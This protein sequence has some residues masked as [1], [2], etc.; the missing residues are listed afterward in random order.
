MQGFK[1]SIPGG[2]KKALSDRMQKYF[3]VL[4]ISNDRILKDKEIIKVFS[5]LNLSIMT[6]RDQNT[7]DD[8]QPKIKQR[9]LKGP[10]IFLNP[11]VEK[12]IYKIRQKLPIEYYDWL[13]DGPAYP[14]H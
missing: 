6:Y 3:G 9:I 13:D 11:K 14:E 2:F 10:C 12:E 7:I 5:K 8:L 4:V 1:E